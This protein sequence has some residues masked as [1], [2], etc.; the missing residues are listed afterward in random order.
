MFLLNTVHDFDLD[1]TKNK[2]SMMHFILQP[3]IIFTVAPFISEILFDH[4]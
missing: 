3:M 1:T 4:G 2:L